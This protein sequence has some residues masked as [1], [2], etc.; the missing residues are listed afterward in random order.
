[1]TMREFIRQNREELDE[2]I[3]RRCP[4]LHRLNDEERR[5]WV[6]NDETIYNIARVNGVRV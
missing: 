3:L 1:M 2:I 6:L 5:Q 4:D